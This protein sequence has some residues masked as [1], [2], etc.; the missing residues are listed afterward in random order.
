MLHKSLQTMPLEFTMSYMTQRIT[1]LKLGISYNVHFF[2]K[3]LLQNDCPAP[4][5]WTLPI[6]FFKIMLIFY[7]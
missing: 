1:F 3:H 6:H 7:I 2:G 5:V 4:A